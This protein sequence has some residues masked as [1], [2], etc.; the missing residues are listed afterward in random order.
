MKAYLLVLLLALPAY[1][2]DADGNNIDDSYRVLDMMY[3][4]DMDEQADKAEAIVE[5]IYS[6][7]AYEKL[8]EGAEER[9][10]TY[11]GYEEETYE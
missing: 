3:T 10:E 11:Y 1:A 7:D 8:E 5:D 6:A 4:T 9:R 2:E